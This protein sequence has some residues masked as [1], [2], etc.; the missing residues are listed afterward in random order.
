MSFKVTSSSFKDGDYLGAE[1]ILSADFG[2]GCAGGNKSPH[3]AWSG[4]PAGT[5]SFAVTCFDPTRDGQRS[6][7][8]VVN[9]PPN[10]TEVSPTPHPR[11]QAARRRPAD[12]HD[13]ARRARR[14]CRARYIR[15]AIC[16]PFR[17]RRRQVEVQPNERRRD[18]FHSSTRCQGRDNGVVH[19]RLRSTHRI[20]CPP[21]S[22][23]LVSN[24]PSYPREPPP[25]SRGAHGS[26]F[27]SRS[28]ARA[29]S[30]T[31][32]TRPRR[33]SCYG[34]FEALG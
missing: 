17:R 1:H 34:G 32:F 4:A 9:I 25:A 27:G 13:V 10:V 14:P 19:P 23:E 24:F 28:R 3:L 18:R 12:A 8:A 33:G 6:A 7:L 11:R 30:P 2:F 22:Y 26:A 29:S 16:S 15:T 20:V 21:L 5:K 31:V